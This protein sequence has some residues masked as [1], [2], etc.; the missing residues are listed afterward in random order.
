M[1]GGN[2]KDSV[3]VFL[4]RSSQWNGRVSLFVAQAGSLSDDDNRDPRYRHCQEGV[5]ASRR[6]PVF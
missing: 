2:A 6:Q 3:P 1:R 4:V 5:P